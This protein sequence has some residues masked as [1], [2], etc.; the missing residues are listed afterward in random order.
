MKAIQLRG[1]TKGNRAI[2]VIAPKARNNSLRKFSIHCEFLLQL[3]ADAMR[4]RVGQLAFIIFLSLSSIQ[5][6]SPA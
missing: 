2:T 1:I 3:L 4:H 5:F 6:Q